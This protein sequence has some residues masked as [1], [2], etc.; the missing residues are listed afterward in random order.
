MMQTT[1]V[2]WKRCTSS[3]GLCWLGSRCRAATWFLIQPPIVSLMACI[4]VTTDSGC[5]W[6]LNSMLHRL[7]VL[8]KTLMRT[9]YQLGTQ[10][11]CGTLST[12]RLCLLKDLMHYKAHLIMLR[13]H[14]RT[15]LHVLSTDNQLVK[16]SCNNCN[17]GYFFS[18]QGFL[19]HC[20]VAHRVGYK[21]QRT[22]SGQE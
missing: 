7:K 9:A 17:S 6:A 13:L 16:L 19:H 4:R 2:S 21:S 8:F 1:A 3:E 5:C 22:P 12:G 15:R 11:H 14:L 10:D 20:W 18:I